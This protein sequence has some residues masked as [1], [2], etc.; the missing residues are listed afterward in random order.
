MRGCR[1]TGNCARRA[2]GSAMISS[3][4]CRS[5]TMRL[6]NL[7][8]GTEHGTCFAPQIENRCHGVRVVRRELRIEG[9]AVGEQPARAGKIGDVGRDLARVDRATVEPP[10]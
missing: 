10:L 1:L 8:R 4:G 6:T 3:I 7:P 9:G 5:S 2:I